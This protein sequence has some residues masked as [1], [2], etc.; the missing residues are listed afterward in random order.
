V[1][2]NLAISAAVAV[3][4]EA[5]MLYARQRDPLPA[6]TDGSAL[7][8]AWLL[9][10]ALPPIAPWWLTAIGS[11]FAIV[12]GKQLFGGLGHNLFNPAMAGYAALIVSFPDAMTR[13]LPAA[14]VT[15]VPL[16][17]L[18][19]LYTVFN[20]HPPTPHSWDA[21]TQATP[22][23]ALRTG[24]AQMQTLAEIRNTPLWGRLG[25]RGFEWIAGAY[26]LGGLWLLYRRL[27]DWRIPLAVLLALFTIA[28]TFS[29]I[30]AD[31][32]PS[33][34]FH[35]FSGA[36]MLCAFFIATDPVSA[37]TTP[38]GRW[39][40]GAGI[41]L[42]IFLI[43]SFGV[44]PDGVAFAVLIMNSAVPLIDRYTVPRPFGHRRSGR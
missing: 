14:G 31:I 17:F 38:L 5:L 7:V 16:G 8:C 40:Y 39:I 24:L 6:L 26:L 37:S 20:G 34:F 22:L 10:L 12:I 44:Y 41:G 23:D 25:G 19:T 36:S 29:L 42:L 11:A 15:D 35:W 43:R 4:A 32:H 28:G 13:W 9:A 18:D 33:P 2:I 30:D 1:L 3:A 27:I 21:I